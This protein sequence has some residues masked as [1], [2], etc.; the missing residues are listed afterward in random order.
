MSPNPSK[1]HGLLGVVLAAALGCSAGVKSTSGRGAAGG[2]GDGRQRRQRRIAGSVGAAGTSGTGGTGGRPV[3]T[4]NASSDAAC[5]PSEDL[6]AAGGQYCGKSATA[7]TARS[8]AATAPATRSAMAARASAG[9]AAGAVLHAGQRQVLRQGRRR[10]RRQARVR[11]LPRRPDLHRAACACRPAA[12]RWPATPATRATAA[13]SATAA[14]GRWRAA[15]A[16]RARPAAAAASRR[17]RADELHAD[18]LHPDGRR[19]VCGRIGNGCGGVLDCPACPGGVACGTGG[20]PASAPGC[21]APAGLHGPRLPNRQVRRHAQDH[22][23]GHGLRPGRQAAALQRDGLRAQR[24][25]RPIV[26][27]VAC[28]KCGTIASGQPVASALSDAAGNFTMQNVPVGRTSRSS[29][30]PGSGAGRSRCPMVGPA[31]TTSS[32][33]TETFRLPKNQSEGH[34]P[35]I[36]MTRG[37]PTAWNA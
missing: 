11:R 21:P 6:R 23:Q 24:A 27:G 4:V 29:S 8:S 30:R 33:G 26:E 2:R 20:G 16:P 7:A 10:L 3:I 22:G 5:T 1:V 14:A 13:P 28:D 19:P 35:K 34:L 36:A 9:R 17:L 31:R 37:G 15:T 18:Q 25:A 12:C 32:A